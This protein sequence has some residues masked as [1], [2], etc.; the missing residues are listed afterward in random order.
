[1]FPLVSLLFRDMCD[2]YFV[3]N[4]FFF[5]LLVYTFFEIVQ[6]DWIIVAGCG[7]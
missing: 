1:M 6:A 3:K 2:P 4:S 7:G 5:T